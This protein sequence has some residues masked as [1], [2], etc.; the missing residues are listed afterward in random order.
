MLWPVKGGGFDYSEPVTE[1]FKSEI[2]EIFFVTVLE[3][4]NTV[5]N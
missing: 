4:D 3:C 5:I 2:Y 1:L